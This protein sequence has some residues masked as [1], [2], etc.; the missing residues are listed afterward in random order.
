[1]LRFPKTLVK[2]VTELVGGGVD[3]LT[4]LA[5][6]V[7]SSGCDTHCGNADDPGEANPFPDAH[8]H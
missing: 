8:G 7:R 2:T 1:L 4:S 3:E 5:L 6:H